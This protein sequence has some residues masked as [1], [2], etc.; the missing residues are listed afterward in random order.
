LPSGSDVEVTWPISSKVVVDTGMIGDPPGGVYSA[1]VTDTGRPAASYSVSVQFPL[2]SLASVCSPNALY[3]RHVTE[4]AS[5]GTPPCVSADTAGA[6]TLTTRP[7]SSVPRCVVDP[8]GS[9]TDRTVPSTSRSYE[10]RTT[11]APP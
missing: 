5:T 7:A 10:V 2:A 3:P 8:F 1:P 9:V 4:L 11:P 6:V